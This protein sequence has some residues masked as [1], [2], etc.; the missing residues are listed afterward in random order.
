MQGK[1][2]RV[3]IAPW[4]YLI[5]TASN[6][7]QAA[8]Y[9]TQLHSRREL[10]ML[11]DVRNVLVV[12]DPGGRRVGSGGSTLFC[13]LEVLRQH[14]REGAGRSSPETWEQV[15]GELR[16]LIVHAGGDSRR[17]PAY[18]P[19]G[20]IFIPVP[21]END[22]ALYLSLFDRLVPTYLAL[23][24]PV[25]GPGQI[26]MASGDV[27]LRF[28]PTAVRF[29]GD[30]MIGLACRAAPEQASRHGV[31]CRGQGHLVRLF[32]QKPAVE[33]QKEQGAID[34]QGQ[35][36]LDIG[37]TH[38][39]A[40][41]A[42]RLLR[43][44][45]ARHDDKGNLCLVGPRGRAI[46]ECGLDFYRE[47]CCA[48]G[49]QANLEHYIRSARDSGSK[50]T[51]A[52]LEELFP[53]LSA[54]P[55]RMQLLDRCEFLDF[56]M[57]RTLI[58]SGARLL[59]EE[60]G[61]A[62]LQGCLDVNNEVMAGGSLQG[63]LG[64]VEGCRIRAPLTLGGDNVVVGVD[65]N[66]PLSLPARMCLDV[67]EGRTACGDD[68]WFVRCYGIDD[69]FKGLLAEGAIFCGRDLRRWLSDVGAEPAEVWDAAVAPSDRSM[70]NA[71]LFPAATQNAG[72]RR[73]L[74]MFDP[75]GASDEQ[76]RAWRSADRYSLEQILALA[77]HTGFCERRRAIRAALLQ[78]SP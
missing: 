59:Q 50:W 66:E 71:R 30:G 75:A 8:A 15:L 57:N 28:D 54:I 12:P 68:R 55:F 25:E 32:L 29:A 78:S 11:R 51:S 60:R 9:E 39:D 14:L 18:G 38:F 36:C 27:L 70:W 77:D 73:W 34:T 20:K 19:C 43:L 17:M 48:M 2:T 64:W 6:E 35:S 10:G 52:T 76:R 74:W 1:E 67:I 13:L 7:R 44:F 62:P 61:A 4:D 42:V 46:M 21:G 45:G 5:V 37:V 65:V 69:T 47:V 72:Y 56:G 53:V 22:G 31:F 23:A 3:G 63:P 41:T 40:N 33:Q 24:K 26:V 49:E 58:A 16:I